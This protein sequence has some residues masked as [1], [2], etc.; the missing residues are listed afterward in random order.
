[1]WKSKWLIIMFYYS[2]SRNI[3]KK[4]NASI[5]SPQT[6]EEQFALYDFVQN[7]GQQLWIG[8][9]YTVSIIKQ[10]NMKYSKVCFIKVWL[11]VW[12]VVFNAT[13]NTI[14]AIS[15]RS[16]LLVMET[17]GPGEKHWPV[18]KKAYIYIYIYISFIAYK[19]FL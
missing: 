5:S 19:A 17:G 12:F 3:C 1:M 15:W 16:V 18:A 4:L 9:L 2:V 7:I 11:M 13:F 14:S 6:E 8:L 10:I